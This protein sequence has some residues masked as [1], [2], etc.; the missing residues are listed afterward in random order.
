MA[1]TW[2]WN[3]KVG[4]IKMANQWYNLYTGNAFL[5]AIHEWE[6]KEGEGRYDLVF[7]ASDEN[8]M[9]NMLGLTREYKDNIIANWEIQEIVEY[10]EYRC[11][12]KIN[13][14][15]TKSQMELTITRVKKR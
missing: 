1:L 6:T 11:W 5:I 4:R 8:H 13:T 12:E 9:K 14:L 7:F 15:L 3:E 2:N 10:V